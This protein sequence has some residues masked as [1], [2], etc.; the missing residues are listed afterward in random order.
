MVGTRY[1]ISNIREN[2]RLL[3]QTTELNNNRSFYFILKSE[4]EGSMNAD[5]EINNLL[6]C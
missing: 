6:F 2:V 4:R 1:E 5:D 3:P